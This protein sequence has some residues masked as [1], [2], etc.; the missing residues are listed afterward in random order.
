M[1]FF[2]YIA[3]KNLRRKKKKERRRIII[4][5]GEKFIKLII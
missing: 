4:I 5:I 2:L 1:T 3:N